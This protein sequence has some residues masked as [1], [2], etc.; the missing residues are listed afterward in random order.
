VACSTAKAIEWDAQWSGNLD[1]SGR[2]ALGV[3]ESAYDPQ[4]QKIPASILTGAATSSKQR[5]IEVAAP[6]VTIQS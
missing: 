1:P 5:I 6:G 3:H 4:P 2:A